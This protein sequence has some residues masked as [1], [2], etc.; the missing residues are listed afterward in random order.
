MKK[1][2]ELLEGDKK[3]ELV[4]QLEDKINALKNEVAFQK[5]DKTDLQNMVEAYEEEMR[6]CDK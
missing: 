4:T 2:I 5:D 1:K 6:N 3:D